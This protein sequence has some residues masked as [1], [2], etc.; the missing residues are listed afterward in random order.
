KL[1]RDAKTNANS[2]LKQA[3][4][5][6]EALKR[7]NS[8]KNELINLG[9]APD[10]IST[11]SFGEEKPIATNNTKAGQQKNRRVELEIK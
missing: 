7:A 8:I 3:K 10:R 1:L 5:D 2:I 9:V 6:N 4:I 11:V